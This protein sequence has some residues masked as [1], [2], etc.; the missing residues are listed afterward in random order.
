[1]KLI[2]EMKERERAIKE[3]EE[4]KEKSQYDVS[5]DSKMEDNPKETKDFEANTPDFDEFRSVDFQR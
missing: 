3:L 5:E 1:M 4:S 2:E